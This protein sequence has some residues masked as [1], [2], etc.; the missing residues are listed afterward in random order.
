MKKLLHSSPST[1]Q[2]NFSLLI[3][4][5]GIGVLMLTHGWPK[6]MRLLAGGEI[7][8]PD[9]LGMGATLSLVMAT[10]TE[11][12]GS[13]LIMLG[14]ATRFAAFSLAFTMAVAVFIVHA[15]DPFSR[16]ELG[17]IYLLAY[18]VLLFTGSGKYSVDRY[19]R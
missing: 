1:F 2:I 18:V 12:L 11:V 5:L 13:V 8:F 9:P 17:L 15:D 7:S 19:F 16:M 6:L 3:L 14:L 10:L 4:R